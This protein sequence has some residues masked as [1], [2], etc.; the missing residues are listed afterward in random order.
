M[1]RKYL[2][3]IICVCLATSAMLAWWNFA[4]VN[5]LIDRETAHDNMPVVVHRDGYGGSES[6]RECHEHHYDKWHASYHRT[7]TQVASPDIVAT[8]FNDAKYVLR[9][10]DDDIWVETTRVHTDGLLRREQRQIVLT[11]GSHYYQIYW[12]AGTESRA[13]EVFPLCYR[14]DAQ[15]WVPFLSIFLHPPDPNKIINQD[16]GAWNTTCIRCH[17]T[18]PRMRMKSKT[19]SQTDVVEFGISCEACHGPSEQHVKNANMGIDE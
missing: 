6:C 1:Q 14:I 11:T 16:S 12:L 2:S 10:Q 5:S 8:K 7:M 4:T 3:I 19:R 17:S 13:L 18:G 9:Y 15:Q